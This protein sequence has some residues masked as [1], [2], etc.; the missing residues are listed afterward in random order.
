MFHYC[1]SLE[2]LK[3]TNFATTTT[4]AL[5]D[6]AYMFYYCEKLTAIDDVSKFN[7]SNV[8]DMSNMFLGCSSLSSLDLSEFE[9][10]K[11]NNTSYMF[12]NCSSL[13]K[14]DLSTFKTSEELNNMAYMFFN[15][16]KLTS[17]DL[18]AFNT[19]NVTNMNCLF[20]GCNNLRYIKMMGDV[21]NVSDVTDMFS[22]VY[23]SGTFEY[24]SKY[25]YSKI[26]EALN[27]F[28]EVFSKTYGTTITWTVNAVAE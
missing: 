2:T 5:T 22:Y 9:V 16:A 28:I 4:T 1:T 8:T 14:L 15:C 18:S 17:L 7:T 21:S 19:S 3:L 13:E 23:S 20:A 25:D 11:V 24:N 6:I 26:K 12:C 10:G 27:A